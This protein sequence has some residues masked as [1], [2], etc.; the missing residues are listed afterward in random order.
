[1]HWPTDGDTMSVDFVRDGSHGRGGERMGDTRWRR[2]TER[3][4]G[5]AKSV[6]HF[7]VQGSVAKS[8]HSGLPWLRYLRQ[9][10]GE[11][12]QFWPFDGWSPR[13]GCCVIAEVYPRL[14]SPGFAAEGRTSDQHD[15]WVVAEWMRRADGVGEL[16][17][18]FSPRVGEGERR[19]A[20][21]EGWI[22]GVG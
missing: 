20:E 22:L 10:M 6:F 11:R 3:R 1:L 13:R 16:G 5:A 21:V 18:W 19:V 14:W 4:S 17:Q 8:T 9:Q 7:D 15:A 2:L 12:V